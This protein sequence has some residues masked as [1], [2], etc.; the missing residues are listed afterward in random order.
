M[1]NVLRSE[2]EVNREVAQTFKRR[3]A[4]AL[5]AGFIGLSCKYKRQE[6]EAQLWC[7]H[8][9]RKI[10]ELESRLQELKERR[11]REEEMTKD[12]EDPEVSK[13]YGWPVH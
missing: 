1:E 4:D 10:R 11:L 6:K 12:L 7:E 2:A 9:E 3:A 5:K 13:A 8:Y